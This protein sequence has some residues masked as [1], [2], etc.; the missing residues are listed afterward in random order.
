MILPVVLNE[1]NVLN[2]CLRPCIQR[3]AFIENKEANPN[4]ASI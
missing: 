2:I 4:G 1:V 3:L